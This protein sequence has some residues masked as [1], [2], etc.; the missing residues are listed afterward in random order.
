MEFMHLD[1]KEYY[2]R[3]QDNLDSKKHYIENVIKEVRHPNNK[4]WN[5]YTLIQ[6]NIIKESKTI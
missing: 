6:K 3:K 1:T 2:K 5:S 4:E